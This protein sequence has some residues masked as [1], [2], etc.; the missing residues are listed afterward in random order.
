MCSWEKIKKKILLAILL[1]NKRYQVY[2]HPESIAPLLVLHDHI[3]NSM[4]VDMHQKT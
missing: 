4:Y 1:D 2:F 3:L